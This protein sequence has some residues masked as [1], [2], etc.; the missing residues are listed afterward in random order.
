[1]KKQSYIIIIIIFIVLFISCREQSEIRNTISNISQDSIRHTV[2]ELCS[3][4]TRFFLA[5]NEHN[6]AMYIAD[7]LHSM[8]ID[9]VIIDSFINTAEFPLKSGNM[10]TDTH[11]NVY[12][13]IQGTEGN[14]TGI[15]GAHYDSYTHEHPLQHAP[16]A[17]NNASGVACIMEIAR[18][19]KSE[20]IQI[21]QDILFAFF[22]AEEFM[23]MYK[24]GYSGAEHFINTDTRGI[25]YMID[26]NQ[27]GYNA[28]DIILKEDFQICPGSEQLSAIMLDACTTYTDIKPVLTGDHIYYS[29]VYYFWQRGISSIMFEEFFFNPNNFTVYD[30]PD[31]LNYDLI[32]QTACFILA[33]MLLISSAP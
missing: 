26:C 21:E 32:S 3:F 30:V 27:I 12:G 22:G 7:R 24:Q 23:T 31:S 33:G 6:I 10:I 18:V 16:G 19:M 8:D 2:N 4:E 1:M 15:L 14:S 13:I 28:E 25:L 11:Y 5:E 17:D 29:D 20:N 9:T